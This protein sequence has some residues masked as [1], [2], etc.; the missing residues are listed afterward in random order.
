MVKAPRWSTILYCTVFTI[1]T[2]PRLCSQEN[3]ATDLALKVSSRSPGNSSALA[4][5]RNTADAGE[6]SRV[7]AA[8]ISPSP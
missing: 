6:R 4:W 8:T 1:A 2:T 3:H 5:E 7:A